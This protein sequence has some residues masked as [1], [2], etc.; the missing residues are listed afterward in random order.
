[1]KRLLP[2]LALGAVLGLVL[3]VV[4]WTRFRRKEESTDTA[5][6]TEGTASKSK[7]G[8]KD[9]KKSAAGLI[10]HSDPREGALLDP[11]AP[12]TPLGEYIAIREKT[13]AKWRKTKVDVEWDALAIKEAL[14]DL[15]GRFQLDA[16]LDPEA[17]KATETI[18]VEQQEALSVLDLMTKAAGL[19]W[20]VTASGELVVMPQDKLTTYAPPVWYD[21]KELWAARESVLADR[22]AG[23]VRESELAKKLR[24]LV[25]VGRSIPAGDIPALVSFLSQVTD[26]NYVM[27]PTERPPKLPAL[28]PLEGE[29]VDAFLRRVLEPVSYTF[30][31]TKDSV[32]LLSK[33]QAEAEVKEAG[34]REDERKGRLEA[35]AEFWK[36]P[37]VVDATNESLRV[38]AERLAEKLNVPVVVDPRSARRKAWYTFKALE[39]PAAKIVD[40]MKSGCPA[41]I[42]WR[43]GKIWVLAPEDLH[44]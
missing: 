44:E 7:T 28:A 29:S 3:F 30:N 13:L 25:V 38:L 23:V 9:F 10:K 41:E 11:E 5:E 33:E 40:L 27:R 37:V 15:K 21:L 24:D 32:I 20:V 19:T 2:L 18:T 39:Q 4:L 31:V 16:T 12:E 1:M 6:A 22:N 14:A 43:N 34:A 26:V 42:T 36:K 35:E 8:P 17:E